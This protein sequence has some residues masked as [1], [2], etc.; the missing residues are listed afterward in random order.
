MELKTI[1]GA[2]FIVFGD[3]RRAGFKTPFVYFDMLFGQFI[4][5]SRQFLGDSG[6]QSGLRI[7]FGHYRAFIGQ[8]EYFFGQFILDSGH[9]LGDSGH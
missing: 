4:P 9:F 5:D 1:V 7:F 8:F 2:V 6:H 3:I